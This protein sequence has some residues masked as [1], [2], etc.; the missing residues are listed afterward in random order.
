MEWI[1]YLSQMFNRS[2][3]RLVQDFL[4][5]PSVLYSF[6]TPRICDTAGRMWLASPVGTEHILVTIP[7]FSLS[8][9]GTTATGKETLANPAWH[10][11]VS[12]RRRCGGE[13]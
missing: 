4:K 9:Y 13:C 3:S 5:N 6:L 12:L 8:L 2:R 11:P 1:N 10:V 7:A